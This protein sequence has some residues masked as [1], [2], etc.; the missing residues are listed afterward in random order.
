[1]PILATEKSRQAKEL[2]YE[3]LLEH[4][5]DPWTPAVVTDEVIE[6]AYQRVKPLYRRTK[7]GGVAWLRESLRKWMED[8]A[9]HDPH[10]DEVAVERALFLDYGAYKNLTVH[11]AEMVRARLAEMPDPW[12]WGAD[13]TSDDPAQR[14]IVCKKATSPR[15]ERWLS[16][17]KREREKLQAIVNSRRSRDGRSVAQVA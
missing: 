8:P 5:P 4:N 7:G 13:L 2:A 1:M 3:V 16:W 15:S 6:E 12:G 10:I 17:P 14:S 9:R 11:E